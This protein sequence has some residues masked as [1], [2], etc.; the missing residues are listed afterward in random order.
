MFSSCDRE[1][2]YFAAS[3]TGDGFLNYF[4]E[5]FGADDRIYILKGGPGTGKSYFL[6]Q[7]AKRAGQKGYECEY[8]LCSSDADSLDG[9]RIPELGIAI[10]DGTAP[11]A[12]EPK[13]PGARDNIINLG[14]FWDENALYERRNE[15]KALAKQKSSSY[16]EA[17][18]ALKVCGQWMR[19]RMHLI[20]KYV[21][22]DCMQRATKRFLK[23]IRTEKGQVKV[24]PMHTFGMKSETILW[25]F[26]RNAETVLTVNSLY[27]VEYLYLKSI[28]DAAKEQGIEV[29]YSPHPICPEYPEAIYFDAQK[30]LISAMPYEEGKKVG[31]RRFLDS[32][33]LAEKGKLLRSLAKGM[34]S[35]KKQA[36]ESFADMRKHHFALETIYEST[37]DFALKEQY[38]EVF[39][40]KL[41]DKKKIDKNF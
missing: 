36:V 31:T 8:Y 24:R 28:L 35:M 23:R 2:V 37:M 1:K 39:L 34:E 18:L 5:I 21:K 30:L 11:H 32:T 26:S 4:E 22:T 38:T 19:Y 10:F 29:W 12:A 9:V 16:T 3:N 40:S 14:A 6:N 27:G 41:L 33:V 13:L 15:I 17:L 25:T 20:S 7:A